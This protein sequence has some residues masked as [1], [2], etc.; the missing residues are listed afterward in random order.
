M[1]ITLL[2]KSLAIDGSGDGGIVEVNMDA[3]VV[4]EAQFR[5][6]HS[7]QHHVPWDQMR[8]IYV[9]YKDIWGT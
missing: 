8:Y 3:N 2:W 6:G 5:A 1:N 9:Y 4:P 7:P